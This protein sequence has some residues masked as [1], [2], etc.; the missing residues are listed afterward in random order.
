[1]KYHFRYLEEEDDTVERAYNET[2]IDE[3]TLSDDEKT[4]T[5]MEDFDREYRFR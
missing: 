5:K 1:M 2:I 4:L 3:E